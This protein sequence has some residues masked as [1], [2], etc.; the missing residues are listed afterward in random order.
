[1]SWVERCLIPFSIKDSEAGELAR[2]LARASL[3]DG[4]SARR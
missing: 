4:R 2:K 3:R 1:M